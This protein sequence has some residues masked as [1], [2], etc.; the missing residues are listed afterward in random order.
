MITTTKNT[1]RGSHFP[2]PKVELARFLALAGVLHKPPIKESLLKGLNFRGSFKI[3]PQ[4][5]FW[6]QFGIA[7]KIHF[8]GEVLHRP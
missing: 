1:F 4:N 2:P 7:P 3:P 6:R 5:D 8:L